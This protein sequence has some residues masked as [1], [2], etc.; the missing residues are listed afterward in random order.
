MTILVAL[1]WKDS[2]K[3][4]SSAWL[5]AHYVAFMAATFSFHAGMA[6]LV[7]LGFAQLARRRKL[8]IV[9]GVAAAIALGP[10]IWAVLGGG[11]R[12]S[13]GHELVLMSFNLMYGQGSAEGV[14]RQVERERPD[15][16]LF[17]EWTPA[18]SAELGSQ[19]A[20]SYP[21]KV[22][23]ARDDAFGQAVFSRCAFVVPPRLYPASGGFREPQITIE[24]E[25]EGR[26]IR[27]TNVHLL[28]PVSLT[29]FAQQRRGARALVEWCG[30]A[31][32]ADRPHVLIG[33]FN[34]TRSSS[35]MGALIKRG[36]R[37]AHVVAGDGRGS[38]WPRT[39]LLRFA[40]GLRLDNALIAPD[41]EAVQAEV[42]DDFGSDHRPIL[43][44]VRWR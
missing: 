31:E 44:G 16:V 28:P 18:A 21:F 24:V 35:V 32:R 1:I 6:A 9:S 5:A 39:G 17:Q 20:S 27:V 43:V 4:C 26:S 38:T 23:L 8:S 14:I 41:V 30:D 19:L 15:V 7:A 12:T 25:H 40:P 42:G 37:E 10:T 36:Y 33:D 34:A 11:A 13:N 22:E 3:P 2:L 29:Y